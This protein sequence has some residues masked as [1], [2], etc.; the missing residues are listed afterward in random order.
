MRQPT[1]NKMTAL[2]RW[3]GADSIV[4]YHVVEGRVS[5]SPEHKADYSVAVAVPIEFVKFVRDTGHSAEKVELYLDQ[6]GKRW[7]FGYQLP[8][9]QECVDLWHYT[10]N[11]FPFWA[12]DKRRL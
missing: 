2:G 8:T 3:Y 7:V 9:T 5:V 11:S 4:G 10:A 12:S 6:E 1:F